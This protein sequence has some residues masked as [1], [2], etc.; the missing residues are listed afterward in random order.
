MKRANKIRLTE[1]FVKKCVSD[2]IMYD[3]VPAEQLQ[4][5]PIIYKVPISGK[6]PMYQKRIM[7]RGNVS[8]M[9]CL[10][11]RGKAPIHKVFTLEEFIDKF[12]AVRDEKDG[13]IYFKHY[14]K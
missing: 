1:S 8:G 12:Y 11:F 7:V 3:A 2:Q 5:T 6:C 13:T 14:N 4:F 10:R 9:V